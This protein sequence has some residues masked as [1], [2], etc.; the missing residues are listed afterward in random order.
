MSD[1]FLPITT[2]EARILAIFLEKTLGRDVPEA[3]SETEGSD[4]PFDTLM[5]LITRLRTGLVQDTG[6]HQSINA[7]V[8]GS[9][10]MIG[11]VAGSYNIPERRY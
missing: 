11:K 7:P 1:R 6:V 4:E 10:I 2:D 8:H 5:G 3:D 9:A